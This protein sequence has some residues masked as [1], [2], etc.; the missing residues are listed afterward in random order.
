MTQHRQ[1][2]R[3]KNETQV[4]RAA[5]VRGTVSGAVRALI[6]WILEH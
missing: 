6:T 4:Y 5:I 3:N 1:H 2:Q